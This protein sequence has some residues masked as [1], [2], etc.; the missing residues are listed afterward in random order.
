M[1]DSRATPT[2]EPPSE[3]SQGR[4]EYSGSRSVVTL[5]I[6]LSLLLLAP[7]WL[8]ISTPAA[9]NSIVAPLTNQPG[10][11]IPLAA[12]P[13]YPPNPAPIAGELL[14]SFQPDVAAALRQQ[15]I[16]ATRP[17]GQPSL[18]E[19]QLI[20]ARLPS[21]RAVQAVPELQPLFSQYGVWAA[22]A[23]DPQLG[24]W[25]LKLSADSDPTGAVAAFSKLP[26]VRYAEPNYPVYGFAREPNDPFYRNQ[27]QLKK[28]EAPAAWDITT[29]TG[30]ITI[31][32]LDTGLAYGH[33]ELRDK[34]LT[35]Q[36]R[37]FVAEPANQFA[38]D[39]NGHGTFV[40]GI[41][42]ASTDN[43]EG[44]AGVAW[45][46]KLLSVKVLDYNEV[47]S[48][49]TL[50]MGLAYV[51]SLPVQVVNMSTGG[52]V[53][54]RVVEDACQKAFDQG[55]VLVAAAGN[56]GKEEY[57]YPAALDTVIAVGASD[58][59][60]NPASYSSY[61]QYISVVAPGNDIV[62]L[63]WASEKDYAIGSGTSFSAPYVSGAVALMLAANPSLNNRQVRN[64]LE[65]TADLP[66][67]LPS[68]TVSPTFQPRETPTAGITATP[69]PTATPVPVTAPAGIQTPTP[70]AQKGQ[71]MSLSFNSHMGWGRL[72]V[73]KA[74]VAARTGQS[75]PSRESAVSGKISGLVNPLDVTLT[76][77]PG[78][79]RYPDKDGNYRFGNLPPGTYRLEVQVSKYGL[80]ATSFFVIQGEDAQN[81]SYDFDFTKEVA[82][83]KN[84]G[85][86]VAAIQGLP[87]KPDD[88]NV[89]F[90]PA[91]GHTL[92]GNFRDF[93]EK[94]G[95]I[96]ILGLPISEEFDENGMTVQ[97][98]ERAVLEYHTD[99]ARTRYAVQPRLL[100]SLLA[101]DTPAQAFKRLADASAPYQPP[102]GSLYFAATGHSLSGPFRQFYEASSGLAIFGYPISEP[103]ERV[104]SK[105]NRRRVQ[106]FQ[107]ARMEYFPEFE[108]TPYV[109]QLGLLGQEEAQVNGLLGK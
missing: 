8:Q 53:R 71:A 94:N 11:V 68:S 108:G 81:L 38:W 57:N 78:D 58:Q 107:R 105:G 15:L 26:E 1:A 14:V 80:N 65:A 88:P 93:W 21:D 7:L 46:A 86:P 96:P 83:I 47:G 43:G 98:F 52:P 79:T 62:S 85:Q 9:R 54:S 37:N 13:T 23:I 84:S 97:Y 106:Y 56:S 77:D 2:P 66:A 27:Q 72:N 31:A 70:P 6:S 5:S 16:D 30:N 12:A 25:R 63:S 109:V 89:L 99:Y 73:Y 51:S 100:G 36:G 75:F 42:A 55:I 59:F 67:G 20:G 64:I 69:F 49:A 60:D 34:I 48:N 41:A 76:L 61:G 24:T 101:P 90:F 82:A 40:A 74:V 18:P 17:F 92:S 19:A 3:A 102:E 45:G 91:T 87:K 44:I 28:I 39:D 4:K 95:G 10:R 103:Y 29:G 104:D 50:A 32:I 33:P 35:D 22:D